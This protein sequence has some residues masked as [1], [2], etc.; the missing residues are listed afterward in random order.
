MK[1]VT[2]TGLDIAKSVFLA[3]GVDA[4]GQA[5]LRRR[6]SRSRVLEFFGK[7]PRQLTGVVIAITA[8]APQVC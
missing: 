1:Q 2:T 8:P 3:H 7:L 5:V 6:L 4:A